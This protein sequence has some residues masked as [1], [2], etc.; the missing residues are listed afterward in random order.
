MGRT[1]IRSRDAREKKER[2]IKKEKECQGIDG[3]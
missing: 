3:M 1:R 2:A